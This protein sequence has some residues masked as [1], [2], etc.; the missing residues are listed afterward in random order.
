[1]HC[2]IAK[3]D[4]INVQCIICRNCAWCIVKNFILHANKI[5]QQCYIQENSVNKRTKNTFF[6]L[7]WKFY[8]FEEYLTDLRLSC[9]G[10]KESIISVVKFS[11]FR[12]LRNHYIPSH[13]C[14]SRCPEVLYLF[15]AI[16][17]LSCRCWPHCPKH[18]LPP[19]LLHVKSPDFL[20]SRMRLFY[21]FNGIIVSLCK[22]TSLG[23]HWCLLVSMFTF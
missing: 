18:F 16:R 11:H 17:N 6:Q 5:M 23:H 9:S 1:M 8:P 15:R 3:Y 14:S 7:V 10:V 12:L 2:R 21:I 4:W 13:K 20:I 22:C 19:Q